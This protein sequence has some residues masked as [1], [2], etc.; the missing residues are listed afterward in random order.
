MARLCDYVIGQGASGV[1]VLGSTGEGPLLDTDSKSALVGAV[2]DG[3]SGRAH[4][5]A[6]VTAFN[7]TDAVG[8][9]QQFERL[10]AAS[11]LLPPPTYFA[12][13]DAELIDFFDAV[14]RAVSIPVVAYN[15][16][17]RTGVTL[18][19]DLVVTLL[20]NGSI[21]G[22]KD[23]SGHHGSARLRAHRLETEGLHCAHLTGS[24]EGIDAFLL[25]GGSGCIPGLANVV[26]AYHVDLLVKAR[27]GRWSEAAE[28]QQ[29]ILP[30]LDLYRAS[31][32]TGSFNASA[33][34][35]LK[36]ALVQ[37]G[38]IQHSATAFPLRQPSDDFSAQ[39]RA[40]L[41]RL[42]G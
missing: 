31:L 30:W 14:A 9:A 36:E 5:M 25:G 16:P 17:S 38:I 11:I 33:I 37:T 27:A 12:L 42:N 29:Q 13:S 6:C 32:P 39:V 8:Q 4:V 1:L 34:G 2:A 41:A 26:P 3:Y 18:G 23:S 15:V 19:D 40:V 20:K 35:A 10:G 7:A 21:T 24:E 28:V 22:I